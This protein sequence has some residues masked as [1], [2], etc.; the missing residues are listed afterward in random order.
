MKA[1]MNEK[2]ISPNQIIDD[3]TCCDNTGKDC[4][5]VGFIDNI[6]VIFDYK[7]DDNEMNVTCRDM[8][9]TDK[10]RERILN[11][12]VDTEK[13]NER[14]I[15]RFY[16]HEHSYELRFWWKEEGDVKY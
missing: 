8:R 2:D 7:T 13:S 16:T 12:I 14:I 6:P 1:L 5:A 10:V 15:A 9:D 4:M 3:L 11:Y